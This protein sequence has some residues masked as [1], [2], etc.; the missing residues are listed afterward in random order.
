MDVIADFVYNIATMTVAVVLFVVILRLFG[1]QISVTR[2]PRRR[3][4][5][6]HP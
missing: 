6:D 4:G 2:K 1:L 5:K 3:D